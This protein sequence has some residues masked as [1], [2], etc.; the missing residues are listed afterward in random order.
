MKKKFQKVTAVMLS[1]CLLVCL[2]M[3]GG[4]GSRGSSGGSSGEDLLAKV[5]DAGKLVVCTNVTEPWNYTD[6]ETGEVTGMGV[7]II[8]GFA[9]DMGVDVEYSTLEFASLI[10]A[11][12]DGK[13]DIIVTNLTRTVERATSK[14]L[15]TDCVGSA[16]IVAVVQ[17]GTYSSIDELDQAGV[18]LTTEAGTISEEIAPDVFENAEMSACNTNA[19][20][21]AALTS[22]RAEAFITDTNV[23]SSVVS[24]NENLEYI[25]ETVYLDTYAFGVKLDASSYTF[26]EAFNTYLQL[27]KADGTYGEIYE[28]YFGVE[29]TPDATDISR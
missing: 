22:G 7:E 6:P 14:V 5:R 20:A 10:P 18:V 19:D 28:K 16:Q 3:S 29:W 2:A 12:E 1:V 25:D 15:Y 11:I 4:C 24:A 9:E 21:I 23:A 27:I 17:K 13:A 8:E 26:V